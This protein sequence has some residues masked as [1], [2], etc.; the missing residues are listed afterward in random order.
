MLPRLLSLD[1]TMEY[2]QQLPILVKGGVLT[3]T[4]DK[5]KF[6]SDGPVSCLQPE[7]VLP[8]TLCHNLSS[9][10]YL[11][12]SSD[13]T[14]FSDLSVLSDPVMELDHMVSVFPKQDH[15]G[16]YLPNQTSSAGRMIPSAVGRKSVRTSLTHTVNTQH[17][18]YTS[19]TS[20]DPHYAWIPI[21][22]AA[23]KELTIDNESSYIVSIEGEKLNVLGGDIREK[24]GQPGR[25]LV[26]QDG[27]F[28][29]VSDVEV[30]DFDEPDEES[31][32]DQEEV[33]HLLPDKL[34]DVVF[35]GRSVTLMGSKLQLT[36]THGCYK[37]SILGK[38]VEVVNPVPSS[39]EPLQYLPV[40][41][42]PSHQP[43]PVV[44]YPSIQ[45]SHQPDP[46]VAYQPSHQPDPVAAYP[47]RLG[48]WVYDSRVAAEAQP[49][50][51]MTVV[52]PLEDLDDCEYSEYEVTEEICQQL[53]ITT[54]NNPGEGYPSTPFSP[55]SHDHLNILSPAAA[56]DASYPY[57][58][59]T[60]LI[61]E[62]EREVTETRA[63]R[64]RIPA[65]KEELVQG[66]IPLVRETTSEPDPRE[67][68]VLV[69]D[70]DTKRSRRSRTLSKHKLDPKQEEI[71][72]KIAL[73]KTAILIPQPRKATYI[74]AAKFLSQAIEE[75]AMRE[76]KRPPAIHPL[77]KSAKSTSPVDEPD[78][79]EPDM[80]K[81]SALLNLP[82]IEAL[83]SK[84]ETRT[85]RRETKCRAREQDSPSPEFPYDPEKIETL[86]QL[87]GWDSLNE[88]V[89]CEIRTRK[90]S[91]CGNK[92][93][94]SEAREEENEEMCNYTA[95]EEELERIENLPRFETLVQHAT[96][97]SHEVT[98]EQQVQGRSGIDDCDVT[99]T[100]LVRSISLDVGEL[101]PKFRVRMHTASSGNTLQHIEDIM[102]FVSS[103]PREPACQSICKPS[104]IEERTYSVSYQDRIHL[105]QGTEITADKSGKRFLVRIKGELVCVREN[106]VEET[107][108]DTGPFPHLQPTVALWTEQSWRVV[109]TSLITPVASR[110]G[111]YRAEVGGSVF[112]VNPGDVYPLLKSVNLLF[113][114][115][116]V[117]EKYI[118]R[119]KGRRVKV[120]KK[121]FHHSP[122]ELD[123]V[124]VKTKKTD[125]VVKITDIHPNIE[126][127]NSAS[128]KD[129][130]IADVISVKSRN[131]EPSTTSLLSNFSAPEYKEN[132]YLVEFGGKRITMSGRN[133]KSHKTYEDCC[134][135]KY[136][137]KMYRIKKSK[138]KLI[139][140]NIHKVTIEKNKIAEAKQQ[141]NSA[142]SHGKKSEMKEVKELKVTFPKFSELLKN[143]PDEDSART[144][145][146]SRIKDIQRETCTMQSFFAEEGHS[147]IYKAHIL[148]GR[149][150]EDN[151]ELT[152]PRQD[153]TFSQQVKNQEFSMPNH[154]HSCTDQIQECEIEMIGVAEEVQCFINTHMHHEHDLNIQEI[155]TSD[156]ASAHAAQSVGGY[157]AEMILE[158]EETNKMMPITIKVTPP[159]DTDRNVSENDLDSGLDFGGL[160]LWSDRPYFPKKQ[161]T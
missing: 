23:K 6:H 157:Q 105:V 62:N 13:T 101:E 37:I 26:H 85:T 94:H 148:D 96:G 28:I 10:E 74:S 55:A 134:K 151:R 38:T 40:S 136:H 128:P 73:A 135:V 102:S 139:R 43:V 156:T 123:A 66:P 92:G 106:D 5:V 11:G 143:I 119:I 140:Q 98:R 29:E 103:P 60:D 51:P 50:S 46:L 154:T 33:L 159:D 141:V 72:K 64:N 22:P 19:F 124:I 118:A 65:P 17:E 153:V 47:S 149:Q 146:S 39:L 125:F 20:T 127:K 82:G 86:L 4:Q 24:P 59:L 76:R 84:E 30:C 61:V 131:S 3:V 52:Q 16:S 9:D 54:N 129:P 70:D 35:N 104:I 77:L 75:P 114:C 7:K 110:G 8:V 36:D 48:R 109:P 95:W 42:Q 87:P 31:V 130:P 67:T 144:R 69:R 44:A 133:I 93:R 68:M 45:P 32:E 108:T 126:I 113:G 121:R 14:S 152:Y 15:G 147:Q 112:V 116:A 41:I 25:F 80:Y 18:Q 160:S 138:I 57:R 83:A 97:N 1:P 71:L 120:P 91:G 111:Q 117:P 81:L 90:Y 115:N 158:A 150:V 155:Q 137:G 100:A 27:C 21:R 2:N 107:W 63:A 78:V 99:D 89:H 161:L 88:R 12:D 132:L 49:T 58:L 56:P 122:N 145:R 142:V 53:W 79:V 34:Y